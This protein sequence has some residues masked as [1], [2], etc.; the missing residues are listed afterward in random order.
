MRKS[1][2]PFSIFAVLAIMLALG[3]FVLPTNAADGANSNTAPDGY[4]SSTTPEDLG[5]T[6]A[7]L[8]Q[9]VSPWDFD[10]NHAA[11]DELGVDYDVINSAGLAAHDLTGYPFIMYASDQTQSYYDNIAANLAKINSYVEGGG[12]LVAHSCDNAWNPGSWTGFS[13]LPG[14]VTQKNYNNNTI[15]IV[16]SSHGVVRC[17]D[18]FTLTEDYLYNWSSSTHGYFTNLMPGTNVVMR[19]PDGPTY[20]DYDYGAGR[21]LAT[22][23]TI[24]WGYYEQEKPE[25]LLNEIRYVTG[26]CTK[27]IMPPPFIPGIEPKPFGDAD[28]SWAEPPTQTVASPAST[29]VLTASVQPGQVTAGQPVTIMAN[30][31]NSGDR[32]GKY[33][34]SLIINGQVETTKEF[35]VPGNG[36][37][38]VEFTVVKDKPGTYTVDIGGQK[39]YFTV[40]GNATKGMSSTSTIACTVLGLLALLAIAL[41]VIYATRKGLSR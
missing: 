33:A 36:A 6:V 11:M 32:N 17:G 30:V 38:P 20:I 25:F 39:A 41:G 16:D 23:Q 2:K 24:E 5:N 21:V 15:I 28:S 12:L 22:M 8:I 4:V 1:N 9:D 35:Y 7:L 29:K 31:R 19:S 18:K 14:G 27:I 26:G 10:S 34:A 40:V 3:A 13:I 37:V